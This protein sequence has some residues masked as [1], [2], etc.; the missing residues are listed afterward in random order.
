MSEDPYPSDELKSHLFELYFTWEQPWYQVV[1]ER[2]FRESLQQNGRF[3]TPLLVNCILAIA[4]RYSDRLEV[5]SILDNP[6]SAGQLFLERA[7]ALLPFELKWPNITTLQSL[8]ILGMIYVA[9][10]QDAAGWLYQGM[11][12]RLALDM[13]LNVDSSALASKVSMPTEEAELRRQI[14]WSLYCHDKLA[15]SYTGRVCTLLEPQGVVNLPSPS[16]TQF[17]SRVVSLQLA[18]IGIC[19]VLERILL[20][21]WAPKPL[22]G[23][24]K[25]SAFFDKCVVKLRSWYYDL[26]SELKIGTSNVLPQVYTLHMVYYTVFILLSKPFLTQSESSRRA[27]ATRDNQE[28]TKKAKLLCDESAQKMRGV[29]Q[30]YR[31]EFG[32]FRL[33]P[34]T[35][36]HCTLSAALVSLENYI[37]EIEGT[38]TE[39][40]SL[41]QNYEI[42]TC[43]QTL[44]ELSTSWYPAKCINLHLGKLYQQTREKHNDKSVAT[45]LEA[46]NRSISQDVK[47]SRA[48]GDP[49]NVQPL[50]IPMSF[51]MDWDIFTDSHILEDQT[52]LPQDIHGV[53]I[54]GILANDLSL[55]FPAHLPSDYNLP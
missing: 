11:A 48:K 40:H 23:G 33:S 43:L 16:G 38:K 12:C 6:N 17:E 53:D 24:S 9:M 4:S 39:E 2:L 32:S 20:S 52:V 44:K 15:A 42:E 19:R 10:G 29:A 49:G 18:S 25:R 31:Q 51:D 21:L 1:N 26:P 7:E 34:I 3:S 13:G 55:S 30:K 41:A 47:Q 50:P 8:A 46:P 5:R 35:A 27:N 45:E 36:T 22:L 37:S 28:I 14:Y 54:E